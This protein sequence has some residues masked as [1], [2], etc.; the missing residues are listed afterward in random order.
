MKANILLIDDDQAICWL[1]N[2]IFKDHN[3][4][5]FH[6]GISAMSWMN[7]GNSPDLIICDYDLPHMTGERFIFQLKNSGLFGDIPVVVLSGWT[8]E[9]DVKNC[10]NAGASLFITKPFD[11]MRFVEQINAILHEKSLLKV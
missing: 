11:P 7:E 3:V 4:V 10:Y 5:Y 8:N 2:R 6:D 9:E 1:L